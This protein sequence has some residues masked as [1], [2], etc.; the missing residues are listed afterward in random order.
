MLK[1]TEADGIVTALDRQDGQRRSASGG[2]RPSTPIG[3]DAPPNPAIGKANGNQTEAAGGGDFGGP[4]GSRF[5]GF[6]HPATTVPAKRSSKIRQPDLD[7][8]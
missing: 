4:I 5:F 2:F 3:G 7:R 6:V 1:P 8:T